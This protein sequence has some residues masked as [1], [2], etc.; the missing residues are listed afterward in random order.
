VAVVVLVVLVVSSVWGRRKQPPPGSRLDRSFIIVVDDHLHPHRPRQQAHCHGVQPVL[1]EGHWYTYNAYR[2]FVSLNDGKL[3]PIQYQ[4]LISLLP[5]EMH[6][7]IKL[8]ITIIRSP[9]AIGTLPVKYC[10]LSR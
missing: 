2:D 1:V 8:F 5:R 3:D 4:P 10:Q 9:L 7:A 6:E